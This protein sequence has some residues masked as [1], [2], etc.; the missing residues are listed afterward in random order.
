MIR[1]LIK[2]AAMLVI[3][4]L[5]YNYFF[6]N[7]TEKEQSRK[8]FGETKQLF[9]SVTG[10]V[11]EE[12]DKYDAGKY[13]KALDRIGNINDD[14]AAKAKTIKDANLLD[15]VTDLEKKRS[16]LKTKIDYMNDKMVN[17][18]NK[19]NK[20]VTAEQEANKADIKDDLQSLLDET[21]AV[22]NGIE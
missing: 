21:Q 16:D 12:K 17:S 4:V 11:R 19:K 5:V 10:L 8:I 18:A 7:T 22:M 1:S 9:Q 14:L 3:V 20:K 15:K 13:D 6:G 2:L